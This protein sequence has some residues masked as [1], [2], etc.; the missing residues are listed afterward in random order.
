LVVKGGDRTA[1]LLLWVT[2]DQGAVPNPAH[3]SSAAL[4]MAGGS[5]YLPPH[6]GVSPISRSPFTLQSPLCTLLQNTPALKV[7]TS[8]NKLLKLCVFGKNYAEG[9]FWGSTK[10]TV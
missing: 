4:M 8:E 9:D 6:P 2:R 1:A 3:T 7:I 5:C 10:T